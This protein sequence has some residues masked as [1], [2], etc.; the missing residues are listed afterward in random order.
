MRKPIYSIALIVVMTAI[1]CR[2]ESQPISD[3][4]TDI[5]NQKRMIYSGTW[6]VTSFIET[7]KDLTSDFSTYLV[8]FENDGSA[9]VYSSGIGILYSGIWNLKETR[10]SKAY[11]M[12][13]MPDK[14]YNRLYTAVPGNFHMDELSGD[15]EVIKITETELWLKAESANSEKEIHFTI[16]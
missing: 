4:P 6:E 16:I 14:T 13:S 15:W 5:E 11:S 1:S 7:G 2:K 8:K 9:V 3:S 10:Y 12:D